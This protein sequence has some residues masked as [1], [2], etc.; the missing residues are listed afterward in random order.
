MTLIRLLFVLLTACGLA[1]AANAVCTT[2]SP[3]LTFAA[4]STYDVK[5]SS[6][7]N[8]SGSAGLAC[9]G[10]FLNILGTGYANATMTSLNNF[11]LSD[12]KGNAIPFQVAADQNFTFAYTQGKTINYYNTTLLSLLNILNPNTFVPPLYA[13]LTAAPNI[14]A[15]TYTDVLTVQWSWKVCNGVNAAGLLCVGYEQNSGTATILV[16]LVVSA[17]CRISAPN[18]SFGSASLASQ[19]QPVSQAVLVDCSMGSTYKVS[20]SSGGNGSARPWRTMS[21]GNN[22]TLQYNIYLPD[23]TTIWDDT[24]PQASTVNNGKGTGSTTP[25]QMQSY[26]AKINTTQT[27]PPA[28]TY[29]DTV[30]VV[31]SF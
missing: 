4:G 10:S 2:S 7:S 14:P 9:T 23:G 30:N 21:D 25:S 31:I 19:F 18:V 22:H 28:G 13:K 12:G 1:G 5:S 29:T 27:T 3:T 15:G 17:D 16:K 8:I 20:F 6:V 11:V 26:I 24:N